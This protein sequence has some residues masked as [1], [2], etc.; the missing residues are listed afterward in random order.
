MRHDIGFG[1]IGTSLNSK[2]KEEFLE[3]EE[4]GTLQK[5]KIGGKWGLS[6]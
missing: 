6:S 5:S 3:V 1:P 4:A 2:I